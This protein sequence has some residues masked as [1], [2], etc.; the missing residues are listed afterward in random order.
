VARSAEP[1]GRND[2]RRPSERPHARRARPG[3]ASGTRRDTGGAR[4]GARSRVARGS[5]RRPRSRPDRGPIGHP[6]DAGRVLVCP[7]PQ[8]SEPSEDARARGAAAPRPEVHRSSSSSSLMPRAPAGPCVTP[9]C[10][11]KRIPPGR[12]CEQHREATDQSP[13]RDFYRS[14]RW[15]DLA[16]RVLRE[17][18]TCRGFPA[19]SCSRPSEQADHILSITDGGARLARENLQ[20]LCG[21]CHSKKTRSDRAKRKR[22]S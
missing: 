16:K 5:H 2:V 14:R 18:P 21:W 7:R 3:G 22:A 12:H 17:E 9:G 15:R 11:R 19:G 6:R 13:D 4:G 10:A 20:A 1:R 8:G